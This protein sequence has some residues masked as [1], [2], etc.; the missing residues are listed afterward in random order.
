M[1]FTLSE[2]LIMKNDWYPPALC[3]H[4]AGFLQFIS[5]WLFVSPPFGTH[6][7]AGNRP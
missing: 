4:K 1:G 6:Y 3:R 2:S 5:Y 7:C